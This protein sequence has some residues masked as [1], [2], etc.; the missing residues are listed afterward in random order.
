MSSN[1][2]MTVP[3]ADGYINIRVGAIIMKNGRFLMV[4]CDYADYYYTVGGRLK[5]GETA[6]DAVKREV[7]EE[8]G[9]ALEI[10]RLAFVHE[11]YYICDLPSKLGKPI[12]EVNY[13]FYMS[14]PDDFEPV[15]NTF[16]EFGS[17]E[18][19]EWISPDSDAVIFPEFF[20][21]EL[22]SPSA[23]VKFISTDERLL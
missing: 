17:K 3:C 18:H 7:L 6:A 8:T 22:R 12:Y 11:N 16:T 13:Y 21:S 4:K 9:C 15:C 5:F 20:K 2:D 19:L 14:V 23:T 10:D 1:I